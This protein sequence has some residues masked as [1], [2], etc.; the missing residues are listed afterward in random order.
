MVPECL[1]ND[2]EPSLLA[3]GS[4][5][6][7]GGVGAAAQGRLTDSPPRPAALPCRSMS[8]AER[9]RVCFLCHMRFFQK[10]CCAMRWE[11]GGNRH[12]E[13]LHLQMLFFARRKTCSLHGV[14][15][16]NCA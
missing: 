13:P 3:G 8:W 10:R 14:G 7:R 5:E 11:I 15:V 2:A 1:L 12:I 6:C 9:P 16:A 4:A